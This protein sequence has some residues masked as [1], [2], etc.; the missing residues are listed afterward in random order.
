MREAVLR[1]PKRSARRQALALQMSDRSVRRILHKDL[2]FHPYKIMIV[3]KLL[4]GD[5]AQRRQF[6]ESILEILNEEMVIMMSD[7]AHFQLDG[8]VNK[9]NCRYWSSENPQVLHQRPLHSQKV[10]VWCGVAQFGIIGPYFFEE[11][12]STVTVTSARYIE[13][14]N[15]F[16]LP[17]LRRRRVNMQQIWFQQDGATAHTARASMQV[18]CDI[19]PQHLISRFGDIHWPPRSPDL[20][21]CDY[22][23]WGYLKSK[24]YLNKPRNIQEL[25]EFIRVEIANVD[26][27]MLGR[28]MKNFE[29][30]LRECIQKEGRHLTDI[31]FRK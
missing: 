14:L 1:S 21:I 7:E 15:R 12:N 30:R 6:C 17:E 23:L 28:A 4:Q 27:E 2:K 11:D 5:F 8:T 25:K 10:T 19:F 13:M 9:Q 3:Q 31:I 20:S 29:V 24:V 22:F 26:E 16:L 18:L